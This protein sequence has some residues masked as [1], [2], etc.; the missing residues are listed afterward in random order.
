[1][2]ELRKVLTFEI[3]SRSVCTI[4]KIPLLIAKTACA[5]PEEWKPAPLTLIIE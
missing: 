4:A 1:M 3:G 5:G 2:Q